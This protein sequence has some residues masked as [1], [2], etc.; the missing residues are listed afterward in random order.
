VP[1]SVRPV[2]GELLPHA[3][4]PNASAKLMDAIDAQG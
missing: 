4:M 1:A 3:A 2:L